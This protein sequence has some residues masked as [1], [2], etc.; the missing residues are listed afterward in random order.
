MFLK[1]ALFVV[2]GISVFL[3]DTLSFNKKRDA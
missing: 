3:A 1:I 2:V